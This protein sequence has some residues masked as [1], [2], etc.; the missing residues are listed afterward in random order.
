MVKIAK[1]PFKVIYH[2][3]SHSRFSLLKT[4]KGNFTVLETPKISVVSI[5][6]SII[7]LGIRSVRY[8]HTVCK[9]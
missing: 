9:Q 4:K 2:K 3:K 6:L 7:T 1:K 5:I 8:K